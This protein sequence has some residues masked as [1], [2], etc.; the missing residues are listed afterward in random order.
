M[1]S[2]MKSDGLDKAWRQTLSELAIN[3]S[4]GWLAAVII[5]PAFSQSLSSLD[6]LLILTDLCL[7]VAFLLLAVKLKRDNY[8]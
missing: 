1:L 4:A 7:S 2:A 8:E 3:L 5:T 6:G